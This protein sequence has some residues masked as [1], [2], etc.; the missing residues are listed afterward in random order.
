M[1]EITRARTIALHGKRG[2]FGGVRNPMGRTGSR[3]KGAELIEGI[4]QG[5]FSDHRLQRRWS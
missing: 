1:H 2:L 3:V 5:G 4:L